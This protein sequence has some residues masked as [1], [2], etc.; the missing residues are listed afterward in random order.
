MHTAAISMKNVRL[1]LLGLC[2]GLAA[3]QGS[4]AE[5]DLVEGLPEY[6]EQ[7]GNLSMYSG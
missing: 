2:V 6:S 3:A 5:D 1:L 4:T 7:L